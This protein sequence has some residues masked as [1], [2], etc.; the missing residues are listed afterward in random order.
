MT[1]TADLR[2]RRTFLLSHSI[3]AAYY[4]RAGREDV[5]DIHLDATRALLASGG[6][7]DGRA[8]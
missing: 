7:R 5:A 3:S 8:S 4:L 1:A 6:V 2:M